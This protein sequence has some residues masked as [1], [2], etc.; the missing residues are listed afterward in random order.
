[1]KK[2]NVI[3]TAVLFF[4]ISIGLNAQTKTGADYFA[5]KWNVVVMGTPNGDATMIFNLEK[6]DSTMTGVVVDTTGTEISEISGCDLKDT[7]IT[8]YFNA[9][10][11]DVTLTLN[12]KDEDNVTGSLFGMFVAEG[13]RI[14][15]AE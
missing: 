6:K 14:K 3:F 12:K 10:G 13:K 1:M 9:S 4:F 5:G 2:V 15:E 8:L 11:Y 7:E